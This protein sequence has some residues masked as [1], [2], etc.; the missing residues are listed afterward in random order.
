MASS[1]RCLGDLGAPVGHPMVDFCN[2]G[3]IH[4]FDQIIVVGLSSAL[5]GV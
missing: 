3:I 4:I 2:L 5:Q 1:G